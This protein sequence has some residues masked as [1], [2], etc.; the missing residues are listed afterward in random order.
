ME[1][2]PASVH[3]IYQENTS[4]SLNR[5]EFTWVYTFFSPGGFILYTN[6]L[7][8]CHGELIFV[9][10][11][12]HPPFWIP[13]RHRLRLFKT[14][15]GLGHTRTAKPTN[16]RSWSELRHN[17]IILTLS[18]WKIWVMIRWPWKDHTASTE[19]F[20]TSWKRMILP[21]LPL[22]FVEDP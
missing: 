20:K 19:I 3:N 16:N 17:Q 8:S 1:L 14:W 2:P 12:Y 22:D 11:S 18:S 4:L 6:S 10:A 9:Y 21:G 13:R 15:A 5:H 7:N